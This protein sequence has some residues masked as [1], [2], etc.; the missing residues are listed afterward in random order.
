[1]PTK[2]NP[3]PED[4]DVQLAAAQAEANRLADKA[5]A[6]REAG[7]AT[8]A[9]VELARLRGDYAKLTKSAR[10]ARNAATAELDA[11]AQ[12]AE[13]DLPALLVAFD[14][15]QRLDAECGAVAGHVSR[16]DQVDPLPRLPNGVERHRPPQCQRVHRG[17]T[18]SD[19]IDMLLHQRADAAESELASRLRDELHETVEAAEQA[20]RQ[21]AT[22]MADGQ[23][24]QVDS[25]EAIVEK[26]QR[27][28]ADVVDDELDPEAIASG[29]LNAALNAAR[30]RRLDALLAEE[31]TGQTGA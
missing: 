5:A 14:R 26:Y 9:A 6:I 12:A 10:E 31:A 8:R 17:A 2:P 18:F 1:M 29:G 22:E 19:Y 15:R 4:V 24:L 13:L 25:P 20:A 30:K 27:A 7:E 11:I 16:L 28:I 3:T 21:Q 23:R